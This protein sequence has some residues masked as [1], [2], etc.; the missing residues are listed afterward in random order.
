MKTTF[1]HAET[2]ALLLV[3]AD[4]AFIRQNRQ[5]SLRHIQIICPPPSIY[6]INCYRQSSRLF[7]PGGAELSSTEGTTQGDPLAM[8]FYVLSVVPLIRQLRGDFTQA[9][10]ADDAQA[11][12]RLMAIREWWNP[13]IEKGPAYGYHANPTKTILVMKP[14]HI[15]EAKRIFEDSGIIITE[16]TRD[17]GSAVGSNRTQ[18]EYVQK[19]VSQWCAQMELLS[20]IATAS[21]QAAHSAYTHSKPHRYSF[22]QR[23][24]A[25][26][27]DLLEP[28]EIIIRQKFIPALLGGRHVSD[29][30]RQLPDLPGKMEDRPLRTPNLKYENSLFVTYGRNRKQGPQSHH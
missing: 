29:L 21:P 19:K 14:K 16:G 3:D 12:G 1:Q 27:H 6:A 24:M 22:L 26:V 18:R 4:N 2:D 8:P 30:E 13:I 7:I 15:G 17:L 11:A 23:T 20:K 9:W 5:L 10:Y 25:D 28:I